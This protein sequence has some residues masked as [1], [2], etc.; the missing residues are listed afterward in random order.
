MSKI[1]QAR[2]EVGWQNDRDVENEIRNDVYD[3]FF[4]ELKGRGDVLID[5][6]VLDSIVD[7]ILA[8]AR[9]RLA[10]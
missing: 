3:F 2:R 6:S 9:K 1:I 4:E 5:P 7:D 10:Q 8:A